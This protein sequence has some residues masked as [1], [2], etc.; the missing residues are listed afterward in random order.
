MHGRRRRRRAAMA[1]EVADARKGERARA[2]WSLLR[3]ALLGPA[4]SAGGAAGGSRERAHSTNAFPGFR[5]LDR[6][7]ARDE[8]GAHSDG[9]RIER[10]ERWHAV[11]NSYASVGGHEVC[12]FTR[13]ATTTTRQHPTMESRAEALLSHR[14]YGVDNTGNVRVWDAEGTLA[15]FCLSVMLDRETE[16]SESKTKKTEQPA[17]LSDLRKELRSVVGNIHE[18]AERKHV[19]CNVLELGAGQAGLAGLVS[20]VLAQ[21]GLLFEF[22]ETRGY[23]A[24]TGRPSSQTAHQVSDI[25]WPL[26][27]SRPLPRLF[28]PRRVASPGGG[29]MHCTSFSPTDIRGASTTMWRAPRW[30]R[31]A[32]ASPACEF[33]RACC[34]G[35]PVP[36]ER[37]RVATRTNSF[38]MPM[39]G[40]TMPPAHCPSRI[41]QR[42]TKDGITSAWRATALTF[43]NFTT[44]S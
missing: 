28:S 13:E 2:R 42:L 1:T 33:K 14:K 26:S 30:R 15:V 32:R 29:G 11:R 18:G 31:K 3:G 44:G 35:I 8:D 34:V 22:V 6:A 37:W 16:A 23:S 9:A 21:F 17:E 24:I 20:A 4:S 40:R 10:G 41:P 43:K 38:A 36:M 27:L 12:F 5:V 25:P 19:A 7:A 39:R